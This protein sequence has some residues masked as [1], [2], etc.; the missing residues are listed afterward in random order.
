MEKRQSRATGHMPCHAVREHNSVLRSPFRVLSLTPCTPACRHRVSLYVEVVLFAKGGHDREGADAQAKL[1]TGAP[2]SNTRHFYRSGLF[3]RATSYS[4]C[5]VRV[6]GTA[7]LASSDWLC[8][9][10]DGDG[11]CPDI[12]MLTLDGDKFDRT[13]GAFFPELLVRS[14]I[15]HTKP[16]FEFCFSPNSTNIST[17]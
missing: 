13:G 16:H 11:R 5:F 7:P 17:H 2:T 12:R 4:L 9:L 6:S 1:L 10:F 3:L 14:S 15:S 8:L